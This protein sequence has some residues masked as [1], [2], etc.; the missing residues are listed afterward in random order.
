MCNGVIYISFS[1]L[2]RARQK[3]KRASQACNNFSFHR[4][5][6]TYYV[7]CGCCSTT[8]FWIF[9]ILFL[10]SSFLPFASSRLSLSVCV[11]ARTHIQSLVFISI[12]WLIYTRAIYSSSTVNARARKI[13]VLNGN[14]SDSSKQNE[15]HTLSLTLTLFSFDDDFGLVHIEQMMLFSVGVYCVIDG[16]LEK[17]DGEIHGK[18]GEHKF[19]IE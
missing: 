2:I 8:I 9:S 18:L 6:C 1:I 15:F 16:A 4:A 3:R 12:K 19:D 14:W 7:L 5:G 17:L 13:V 10:V 11:S